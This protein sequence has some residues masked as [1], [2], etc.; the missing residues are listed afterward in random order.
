MNPQKLIS[1]ALV[2]GAGLA[3]TKVLSLAWRGVTGHEPPK[4][5]D[6]EDG[7]VGLGEVIVFAAVS[8]A[9]AALVK[10][11]ATKGAARIV[12]SKAPRTA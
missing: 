12:G 5:F 8:G 9:L 6:S 2:M 3:A 7:E 11:Y 1:T 4:E 10:V